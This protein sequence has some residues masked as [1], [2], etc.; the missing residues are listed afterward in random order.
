MK[1]I[2]VFFFL[3]MFGFYS[4]NQDEPAMVRINDVFTIGIGEQVKMVD[5]RNHML[6]VGI[7]EVDDSR[8]PSDV[9][10]LQEGNVQVKAVIED[11]RNSQFS[12]LLCL[13]DCSPSIRH[14]KSFV[15]YSI[16]YTIE[17]IDVIPFPAS[18]NL[19]DPR[20]VVLKLYRN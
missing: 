19:E 20:R 6:F 17:V 16:E 13:G 5:D 10:C 14:L 2:A 9:F 15:F 8:C 3:V 12:T 11:T 7:T 4:C 18:G 1:L